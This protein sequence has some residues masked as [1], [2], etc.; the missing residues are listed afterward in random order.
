MKYRATTQQSSVSRTSPLSSPKIKVKKHWISPLSM[1]AVSALTERFSNCYKS[2]KDIH[3]QTNISHGQCVFYSALW[4]DKRKKKKSI[5]YNR[6]ET[7]RT[8]LH[9][10]YSSLNSLT[11]DIYFLCTEH[12]GIYHVF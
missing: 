6:K 3:S 8:L 5:G 4:K 10:Q 2:P 7:N 12:F 1:S 11:V 9:C